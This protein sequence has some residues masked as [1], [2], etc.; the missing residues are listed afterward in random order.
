MNQIGVTLEPLEF[1]IKRGSSGTQRF[2]LVMANPD[3]TALPSYDGWTCV[4]EFKNPYNN[5]TAIRLTPTVSGDAGA[6]TLVFDMTFAISTTSTLAVGTY[7]GDVCIVQP[8]TGKYYYPATM[9]LE[10]QPSYAP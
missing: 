8:I 5:Q 6:K 1:A 10:I 4:V 7:S 3:G 9:T 2:T